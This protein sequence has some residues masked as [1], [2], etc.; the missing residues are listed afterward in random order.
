MTLS[1]FLRDYLY[2]PLGG[3]RK[4]PALR[5]VNL[6]VT[7]LLGG[8]WHGANWT[9]VMWGGLHGLYLCANHF[10][11]HLF[12]ETEPSGSK[13]GR[14]FGIL[15][16]FL[17]VVFAW[18]VF[19]AEN[20]HA[21]L[22]MMKGMLGMNGIALPISL[23]FLG[24]YTAILPVDIQYVGLFNGLNVPLDIMNLFFLFSIAFFVIWGLPNSQQ[25]LDK[26][27]IHS[28]PKA[29]WML[30]GI[31][32]PA[33]APVYNLGI[34]MDRIH[35]SKEYLKH[36]LLHSEIKRVILGLD[37]F[38]FNAS[39]KVNYNFDPELIGRKVG[40]GDYLS[41]SIFSRDAF[42]DSIRTI[43]ASRSQPGREEFLSNGFRPGKFVFYQVKSYPALHYYTQFIFMSSLP[44]QTKYYADMTLDQEVF[45]DFEEILKICKQRNID[46][47]LYISPAH[48]HLDGEGIAAAGK[49]GMMEEWKRRVVAITDKYAAP[50]WDF[51]GYNSITTEPVVAPMK[52]YWDSS[53]FTEVVSDLILK[54]MLALKEDTQEVPADF[55]IHLT[56]KNIELNLA[57]IRQ[58]RQKY[59]DEHSSEMQSLSQSYQSYL[60]GGAMDPKK[61]EG[62][63]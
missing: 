36:A 31:S 22:A 37:F 4:G 35:E 28:L 14:L 11:R 53:H 15:L 33:Y 51:S 25:L 42:V 5:Y 38:M 18:V 47:K 46:V 3:S 16:T 17:V 61:I 2:I 19:R 60:H 63:F 21:A 43:K 9:F 41:T 55:G 62:M 7:M 59:I 39:Q 6:L 20:M 10:W 54:R 32:D 58:C 24:K 40:V 52:Y 13:I 44:S 23:A 57:M 29:G 1:Q 30:A 12:G 56:G 8:L 49:W 50:I 45:D 27:R 34:D 48:A 26:A